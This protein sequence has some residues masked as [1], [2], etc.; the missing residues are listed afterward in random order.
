MVEL[1]GRLTVRVT[2]YQMEV[3]RCAQCGKRTRAGL[4]AGVPQGAFGPKLTAVVATLTGR[5][6]LSHREVRGLLADLWE[7]ALSLGAV[8]RLQQVQSAALKAPYT[9][10]R[11]AVQKAAVANMDETGWREDKHRAWLW[12]VVTAGLAV[13]GGDG[14]PDGVSN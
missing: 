4:P 1:V 3:R 8:T 9:A 11:E 6:R 2:E 12:T 14:E 13:D 10:A 5:Y 7:V